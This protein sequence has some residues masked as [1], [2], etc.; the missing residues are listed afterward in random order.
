MPYLLVLLAAL[1]VIPAVGLGLA[2]VCLALAAGAIV[3]LCAVALG[4]SGTLIGWILAATALGVS[5][6][7]VLSWRNLMH[8]LKGALATVGPGIGRLRGE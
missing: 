3:L 6:P 2:A 1:L 8:R 7:A 4:A 5:W